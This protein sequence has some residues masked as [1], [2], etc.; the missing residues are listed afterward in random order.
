MQRVLLVLADGN[1]TDAER[2]EA[3]TLTA[4][5]LAAHPGHAVAQAAAARLETLVAAADP[6][7]PEV[8]EP[9][10]TNEPPVVE[11]FDRLLARANQLAEVSCAQAMP[12][13]DKAL[14]QKATSVEA[15]TGAGFCHI[16]AGQF[17]SAYSKFNAALAISPRYERALWGM[18]EGY[19]QQGNATRAIEAYR[20]YLEVYPSSAA[21]KKQ[22]DRLGA[23]EP[24]AGSATTPASGSAT[25]PASTDGGSTAP[26]GGGGGDPPAPPSGG[27]GDPPA[28]PAD[29][30]PAGGG[31]SADPDEP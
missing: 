13:F 1:A 11:S 10:P 27:G 20:R 16:D 12:Y 7:P 8:V 21:A 25:T 18:A 19:Q 9:K 4:A 2:D 26:S 15:L 28:P 22:L 14:Q 30:E 24:A 31:P 17:S 3:R 5:V 6:M 29:D 23:S